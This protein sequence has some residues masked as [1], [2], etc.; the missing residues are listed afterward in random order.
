MPYITGHNATTRRGIAACAAF[1][2]LAFL[3]SS[4]G[5]TP[6]E[7]NS[8]GGPLFG[9]NV[10]IRDTTLQ[11]VGSSSVKTILAMN[12]MVNL[13]GRSGN[14]QASAALQFYPA[15]FPSRDTIRVLSAALTLRFVSWYGDSLG[16]L[17]FTVYR[18]TQTWNQSTFTLDSV[19]TGF[20]ESTPARGS[21]AGPVHAD[22]QSIAVNLDTSMVREWFQ[23]S[24]STTTTKYG[25]MLVPSQNSSVVRGFASFESDSAAAFPTLQVIALGNSGTVTDTTTY[26]LGQDTFFGSIDNLNT[27][28]ALL[29]LQSG[30]VYRSTIQFDVSRIPRGAVIN[31]STLYLVRDA[32]TSKVARFSGNPTFSAHVLTARGDN[33][34]FEI[35]STSGQRIASTDTFAVDTRHAVQ[36]WIRGPNYGLLLRTTTISEFASFDLYTFFD[37]AATNPV[38]R[39]RLKVTYTVLSR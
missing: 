13:I 22:T 5:D 19:Q 33:A 12:S 21:Y 7:V 14:Y 2:L 38:V 36:V 27:N 34:L 37:Q 39:P 9:N 28:P 20:Y 29:Y 11:A 4:C 30:V 18:I 15:Y 3:V 17:A 23:T 6:T 24:T 35:G 32:S 10:L 31:S 26:T 16:S 1:A 8:V 25:I